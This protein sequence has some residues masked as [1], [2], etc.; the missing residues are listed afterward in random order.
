MLLDLY[1][2]GRLDLDVMLIWPYPLE[3]LNEGAGVRARENIHG[4]LVM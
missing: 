3:G 1:R 2:D 4:I